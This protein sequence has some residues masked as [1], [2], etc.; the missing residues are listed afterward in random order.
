[1]DDKM[2]REATTTINE[3]ASTVEDEPI[4]VG[5]LKPVNNFSALHVLVKNIYLQTFPGKT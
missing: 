3:E 1:M 4:E 5:D 2:N